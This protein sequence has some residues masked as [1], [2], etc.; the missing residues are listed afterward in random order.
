MTTAPPTLRKGRLVLGPLSASLSVGL[1]LTV[2]AVLL[3]GAAACYGALIG[4]ALV[5]L[6]FAFGAL[7]VGAV[8]LVAPAAS[9]LV[10]LL[11]YTL[12]VAAVGLA[13]V[14]LS[15]GGALDGP[16]DA[17]WLSAAV[18]ACTLTW[19]FT[20]VV[21]SMKVRQPVYDLPSHGTEASVR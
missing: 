4:T 6:V 17:R 1:A 21:V 7:V 3:G 19:T 15:G 11:T 2:V 13:Y 20:H 16:V 8:A 12:Q 18:I 14:G 10:A 9:L 5:C